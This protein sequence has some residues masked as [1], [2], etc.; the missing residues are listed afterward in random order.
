L[1]LSILIAITTLFLLATFA[2]TAFSTAFRRLQKRDSKKSLQSLGKRFFY[3]SLH[4]YFFP[5]QADGGVFFALT[6]AQTITRFCYVLFVTLLMVSFEGVVVDDAG[7]VSLIFP[8]GVV[9]AIAFFVLFFLVGD[10]IP[11]IIGTRFPD[12]M[13][14]LEA[15]IVSFFMLGAFP[16]AYLFF[17]TTSSMSPP[18]YFDPMQEEAIQAQQELFDI[19]QGADIS[20]HLDPHDKKLIESVVLFRERIAR[21]VMVPRVDIFGL[22]ADITI[23]EAAKLLQKEGYSRIPVYRQSLD[24]IIGVLMYKDVLNKYMESEAKINTRILEAPIETILK[25]VLYTP[26][27]KKI[28]LLLQEFRKKQVHLAIVVDEYGGT[29]GVVTIEDIL[30]EIVGEIADEYDKEE[31]LYVALPD[32]GWIVDSRMGI[33]DLEEELDIKIPQE[34]DYD[35]L[36]GYIFHHAGAIPGKGYVIKTDD[37]ELE[38][39]RSTDRCVEKVRIKPILKGQKDLKDEKD[40]KDK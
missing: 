7:S 39:L 27:T 35:T 24:N 2:L 22:P 25:N 8:T 9:A 10:I 19:I 16:F 1:N 21:E 32:G 26:E 28:S 34:G 3:R 12:Q 4:L 30:E 15:P 20:T 5:K 36:G 11:R 29:E 14:R 13:I 17:K 23:K 31:S 38:V 37:F 40:L 6:C 33:L 18:I